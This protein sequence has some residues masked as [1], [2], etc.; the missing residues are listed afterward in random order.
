MINNLGNKQTMAENL[1]Y[2]MDR[3]GIDRN[4]LCADLDLKYTT[5]SGWLNAEKY[6]RI[7]KIEILANYFGIKKS[8]LVEVRETSNRLGKIFVDITTALCLDIPEMMDDIEVSR[9]VILK[10]I[11]N[12]NTILHDEFKKLEQAYGIP[13]E[14]WAGRKTFGAWYHSLIHQTGDTRM[15][16]L[17]DRLNATGKE[18]ALEIIDDMVK[19]GKYNV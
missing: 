6:P 5:V 11:D 16:H 15:N 13:F 7:N 10:L 8:D 2:Y 12:K 19:S 9:N 4:K 14:V 18:R 1:K 3:A 17:F